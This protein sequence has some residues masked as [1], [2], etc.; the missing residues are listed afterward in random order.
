MLRRLVTRQSI[1]MAVAAALVVAAALLIAWRTGFD[2]AAFERLRQD[3]EGFVDA[4]PWA[5]FLALV[6][7]PGLPFP[8]SALLLT[9]GVVWHEH[10]AKACLICLA[11]LA[12]NMTWTYW[13]AAGPARGAIRRRRE[14]RRRVAG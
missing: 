6:V 4:R 7:L 10:P 2:R 12:L 5:L 9:A 1:R 3:A 8:V 14:F 11:A 13:I